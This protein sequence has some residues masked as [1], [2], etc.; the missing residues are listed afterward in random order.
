MIS[1]LNIGES[2]YSGF[3]QKTVD[4]ILNKQEGDRNVTLL[5]CLLNYLQKNYIISI[6]DMNFSNH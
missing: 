1:Y 4:F 3:T 2:K 6:E 5:F